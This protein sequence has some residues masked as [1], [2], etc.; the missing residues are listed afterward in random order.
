MLGAPCLMRQASAH[1]RTASG[2]SGAAVSPIQE[3]GGDLGLK[4]PSKSGNDEGPQSN[5]PLNTSSAT[6]NLGGL[7][8]RKKVLVL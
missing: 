8:M 7:L 6:A 4:V 3:D 1:R 5:R 2:Q